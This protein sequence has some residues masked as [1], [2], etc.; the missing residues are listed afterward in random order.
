MGFASTFEITYTVFELG[1]THFLSHKK[2]GLID[3]MI[4]RDPNQ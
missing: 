1:F 4:I 2:T 3:V